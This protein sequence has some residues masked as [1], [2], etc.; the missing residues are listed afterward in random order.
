ME[1][2]P[3]SI[4]NKEDLQV[5][6]KDS[7]FAQPSGPTLSY[8]ALNHILTQQRNHDLQEMAIESSNQSFDSKI[9]QTANLK[10]TK[11]ME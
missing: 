1:M 4:V 7:E 5:H 8:V 3:D 9:Y 10:P 6:A 11:G 2:N